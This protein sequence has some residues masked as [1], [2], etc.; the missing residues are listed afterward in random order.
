MAIKTFTTGEV[1]TASDTNTYLSNSGL[2]YVTGGPLA[3]ATTNF[4]GCF[5]STYRNYHVVIDRIV[6][7]ASTDVYFRYMSGSTPATAANYYY[8]YRAL[9][10]AGANLDASG[11]GINAGFLNVRLNNSAAVG[12]IAI[13]F[14]DPQLATVSH[15][16][17]R[18][19]NSIAGGYCSSG[20]GCSHDTFNVYDG[21]QIVTLGAVTL[22]GNVTV[23][24]YRQA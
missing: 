15:V 14:F 3:T 7:S 13:D 2:V 8:A 10:A 5:T 22:T 19:Q 18:S 23:Y 4:Q 24:G 21:F 1:L 17:A 12:S 20:G 16:T 9:S 6:P 11:A